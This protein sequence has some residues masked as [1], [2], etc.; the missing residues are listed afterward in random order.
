MAGPQ[1]LGSLRA[2]L[3]KK[4]CETCAR[5][6]PHCHASIVGVELSWTH[7]QQALSHGLGSAKLLQ[8]WSFDTEAVHLGHTSMVGESI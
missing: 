5:T 2:Q 7:R 6:V 4:G 1:V 8:P 3:R